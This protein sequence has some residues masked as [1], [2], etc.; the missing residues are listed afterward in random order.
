MCKY[1]RNLEN[2]YI[3]SDYFTTLK[4]TGGRVEDCCVNKIIVDEPML[5]FSEQDII[6]HDLESIYQQ[7]LVIY[8]GRNFWKMNAV[9]I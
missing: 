4:S 1:H 7:L 8:L 9:Y 6:Q 5:S 2:A 3:H